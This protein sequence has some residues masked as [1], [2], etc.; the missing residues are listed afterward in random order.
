MPS[1]ILVLGVFFLRIFEGLNKSDFQY[2]AI[3]HWFLAGWKVCGVIQ[4]H[5]LQKLHSISMS[6]RN[7]KSKLCSTIVALLSRISQSVCLDYNKHLSPFSRLPYKIFVSLA[8]L[9]RVPVWRSQF[10]GQ[11]S[12]KN[13][14]P[15]LRVLKDMKEVT[16]LTFVCPRCQFRNGGPISNLGT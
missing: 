10:G 2:L 1:I 16:S 9:L 8:W 15:T 7:L 3:S 12:G 4:Q 6:P 11:R 14:G 13:S 5:I